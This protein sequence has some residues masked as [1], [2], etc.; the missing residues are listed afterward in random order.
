MNLSIRMPCLGGLE[1]KVSAV[2][3]IS[4]CGCQW[5]RHGDLRDLPN[6]VNGLQMLSLSLE[7]IFVCLK[8]HPRE[9]RGNKG[10][11][12]ERGFP[13]SHCSQSMDL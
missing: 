1:A 7:S 9:R 10:R 11:Y 2:A 8:K 3:R 4:A 12:T 6:S 5:L 13:A